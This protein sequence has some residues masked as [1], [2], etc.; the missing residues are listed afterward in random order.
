MCLIAFSSFQKSLAHCPLLPSPKPAAEHP[1]DPVSIL[2]PSSLTLLPPPFTFKDPCDYIR[3]TQIIQ[4]DLFLGELISNLNSAL[5][6]TQ[7]IHTSGINTGHLVG[8]GII[9]PAMDGYVNYHKC[10]IFHHFMS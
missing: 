2:T 7:H 3:A 10:Y 8:G 9:L 1:F 6:G 4:N 5:P